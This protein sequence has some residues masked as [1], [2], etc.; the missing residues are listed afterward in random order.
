MFLSDFS[1]KRPIATVVIIIALMCLG[2]LAL[3]KL[4][5][6]QIPDVEQPVLVVD[7][8]L[9]GRV[10]RDGRARDHQPHREVAA[11]HP[12]ASTRCAPPPAK[13]TRSI[14]LIF[15]FEKNMIE[16]ADEVRNAIAS[17]RHKLPMEMREPMLHAHRPVGAADHAAGAVV[18]PRRATPRSRA[19]PRTSWPTASAPSPAWPWSTSTARCGASS[20]CCCAPRSCASTRLGHR[21]GQRAA[22]AEH[23]RAGGQGARRAGRAEHP[24]GRAH[25]VAGRVRADRDQA[26][27]QRDACAWGRWPACRTASPS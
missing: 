11:E 7:D 2:L 23:H 4:R 9:S 21:G 19:W 25:R 24:P 14:V 20:R 12:A 27:R 16:A 13:A 3:N 1:I 8:P 5:V 10:A 22:R 6:N 17:V 15:N 18:A 26:P